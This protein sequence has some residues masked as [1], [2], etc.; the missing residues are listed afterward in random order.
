MSAAAI[1]PELLAISGRTMTGAA[2]A[3][4]A[5]SGRTPAQ[6]GDLTCSTLPVSHPRAGGP[7]V[8]SPVPQPRDGRSKGGKR[9]G[10]G[11]S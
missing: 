8:S 11:E 4:A 5:D 9:G 2:G 1:D 6:R 10:K 7:E 3:L